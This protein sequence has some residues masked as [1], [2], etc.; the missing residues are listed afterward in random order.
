MR[1]TLELARAVDAYLKL[2]RPRYA[3]RNV[4]DTERYC[5]GTPCKYCGQGDPNDV[6]GMFR[7]ECYKH[8]QD[9]LEA[10][11]CATQFEHDAHA[12]RLLKEA[13]PHLLAA[14]A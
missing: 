13:L 7:Q 8:Q 5:Y 14:S 1:S 10:W 6:G 3:T 11:L 12:V 2:E 9:W 4:P